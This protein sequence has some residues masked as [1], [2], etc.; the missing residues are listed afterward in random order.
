MPRFAK[1][2]MAFAA[3]SLAVVSVPGKAEA[4]NGWIVPA[5]VVGGVALLAIG[6]A[7]AHHHRPVYVRQR[8]A[9]PRCRIVRER[10]ASGGYRRV[11]V[12]G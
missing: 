1:A 7:H 8:V 11:E 3:I 10:T 9:K 5:L 2:M 4:G 12:C 6:A